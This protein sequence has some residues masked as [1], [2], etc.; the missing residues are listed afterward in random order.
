MGGRRRPAGELLDFGGGQSASW[1]NQRKATCRCC[2]FGRNA[3]PCQRHRNDCQMRSEAWS[4][5]RRAPESRRVPERQ[6]SSP[7]KGRSS[8]DAVSQQSL[9]RSRCP[10]GSHERRARHRRGHPLCP[11]CVR[12]SRRQRHGWHIGP[13][14][15]T[16]RLGQVPA[17][18]LCG[19]AFSRVHRA[20]GLSASSADLGSDSD[21]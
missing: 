2:S 3:R 19:R 4:R 5:Q 12:A 11:S 9:G 7:L 10:L 18:R 16:Q 20:G 6:E 15:C 21:R 8:S 14:T 1:R 13:P 17:P